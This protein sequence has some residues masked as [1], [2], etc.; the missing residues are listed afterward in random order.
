M[1]HQCVRCNAF[2]QDGSEAL[3]KGCSTCGG[4]FFFYVKKESRKEAEALTKNLTPEDKKQMERDVKEII[5]EE[6]DKHPVILDLENIKVLQPGKF[7]L[8]LVDLF[9]KKPLVYRLEEGKYFIDV[10]STFAAED[11]GIEE[12]KEDTENKK[13][14]KGNNNG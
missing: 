6:V 5:G 10:P 2:Y 14:K 4:K 9:R 3:L 7:E 1:P 8:D 13:E 11:L 12:K